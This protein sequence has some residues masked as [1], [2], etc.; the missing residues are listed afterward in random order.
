MVAFGQIMA[1]TGFISHCF[2]QWIV[3][4]ISLI[5]LLKLPESIKIIHF[6]KWT[7]KAYSH[8]SGHLHMLLS[9]RGQVPGYEPGGQ[10]SEHLH[11]VCAGRV[12]CQHPGAVWGPRWGGVPQVHTPDPGGCRVPA[13]ERRHT[14]VG[15]TQGLKTTLFIGRPYTV[16][17]R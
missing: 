7:S 9:C 3:V 17:Y 11:A 8:I 12:H 6:N 2:K 16:I 14:Q 13:R 1:G 5:F 15:Y 4:L 10:H